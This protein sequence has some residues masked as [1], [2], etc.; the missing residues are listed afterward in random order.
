[1]IIKQ[2]MHLIKHDCFYDFQKKVCLTDKAEICAISTTVS[3][4]FLALLDCTFFLFSCWIAV[5]SR[6]DHCRFPRTC[7]L[8]CFC[9]IC[10]CRYRGLQIW[11]TV[12]LS[13]SEQWPIIAMLSDTV[14][15][16]WIR[17]ENNKHFL[18]CMCATGWCLLCS[19]VLFTVPRLKEIEKHFAVSERKTCQ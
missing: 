17:A 14:D 5:Q 12:Q 15:W 10:S 3:V 2:C 19:M 9:T 13:G 16:F 11:V 8:L 6:D 4:S 18:L 7:D 1:M